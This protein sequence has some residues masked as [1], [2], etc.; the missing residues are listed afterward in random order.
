LEVEFEACD[1]GSRSE[2][3][4]TLITRGELRSDRAI[5]PS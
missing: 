2:G 5:D 4:M 1:I 3:S